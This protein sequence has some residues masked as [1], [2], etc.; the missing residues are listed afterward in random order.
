[1]IRYLIIGA[2]FITAQGTTTTTPR[3]AS[4]STSTTSSATVK[5]GA[6]LN[7]TTQPVPSSIPDVLTV[8]AVLALLSV[9]LPA[10]AFV[11]EIVMVG[12]FAAYTPATDEVPLIQ[13]S[14]Q[15]LMSQV[16]ISAA[17]LTAIDLTTDSSA[18]TLMLYLVSTAATAHIPSTY[19]MTVLF[20]GREYSCH[21]ATHLISPSVSSSGTAIIGIVAAIGVLALVAVLAAVLVK[22]RRHQAHVVRSKCALFVCS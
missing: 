10:A 4:T 6:N 3:L 19:T 12:D 2:L 16:H 11:L 21:V 15:S 8:S 18:A 14:V 7:T 9:P 13:I 20:K 22:R 17:D 5:W 1:M